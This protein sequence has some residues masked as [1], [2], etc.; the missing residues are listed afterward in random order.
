MHK[1]NKT[2]SCKMENH[3]SQDESSYSKHVYAL[4]WRCEVGLDCQNGLYHRFWKWRLKCKNI[5]ECE[6]AMLVERKK[7]KKMIAWS[8]DFEIDQYVSWHL[9]NKEL[10]LDA[11]WEKFDYFCK[12][13]S[14]KVRARFGL[15]TS[16]SQGERSVNK[17]YNAVQTQV[18]LAKYSQE[19]AKIL[20]RD[21]FWFFSR[22]RNLSWRQLMIV[23]LTSTSSPQ[24]KWDNLQNKESSKATTKHIK[25]V[26]SDPQAAQIHMMH[27]Q[28][29]E[30]PS[31]KFKRKQKHFQSRQDN[32]KPYY[33]E[34]QRERM[35]QGHK[36][37]NNYQAHTS[38]ESSSKCGNSQHGEGFRYAAS[39]HQCKNCHEYGHF[40]SLC[41]KKREFEHKRSLESGWPKAHQ[42]QIGTVHMQDSI[43]SQLEES[44]SYDSFCL[45]VILKFTQVV[46]KIPEPQHLTTNL[47]FKLKPNQK[48]TKYVKARLDTYTDINIMPVS[49]YRLVC[50]DPDCKK[51]APSS[52][53]QIGT[54]S[55]DNIKVIGSCT[56]LVV[57]PDT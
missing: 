38:Q 42:L 7:C 20:H 27:H 16:F 48:R 55:T 44:S 47:A 43:Y 3:P 19:T 46:T 28:H 41:Y 9:T 29:T 13:Q 32:N 11:I 26:A 36:K 14:N 51:L 52:K 12:P 10:T 34:K 2:S 45:Q 37:Y 6:F 15:F 33:K 56:L 35:P 4:Y 39:K 30:L 23:V 5:L 53:L 49:V 31:N 50:K 24:A 57:H 21:I 22:M 17:W 25:Q 8:K 54:Y 40:S 1:S 18:T